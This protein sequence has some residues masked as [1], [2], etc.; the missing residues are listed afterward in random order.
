MHRQPKQI[1]YENIRIS[2]DDAVPPNTTSENIEIDAAKESVQEIMWRHVGLVRH[3]EDLEAISDEL[4]ALNLNCYWHSTEAF[5]FQNMRDV[6]ALIMEAAILRTESRGT[7]YREDFPEQD[8]VKW[9]K[10]IVLQ[11][12]Q[13]AR[14]VAGHT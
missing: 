3:G 2:S 14:I 6:A 5:E 9:K 1:V 4:N 10:H 12:G 11:R 7:H 13:A 8:D